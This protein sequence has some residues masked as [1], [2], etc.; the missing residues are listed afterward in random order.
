[1]AASREREVYLSRSQQRAVRRAGWER[2]RSVP[3]I[4]W[5]GMVPDLER[6]FSNWSDSVLVSC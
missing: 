6:I 5:S 2:S 1:V 4:F 3:S